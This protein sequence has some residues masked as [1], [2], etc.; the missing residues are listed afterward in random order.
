MSA[1]GEHQS[2]IYLGQGDVRGTLA[3]TSV[4]INGATPF[5]KDGFVKMNLRGIP[6]L[7]R[8]ECPNSSLREGGRHP[9]SMCGLTHAFGLVEQ[10]VGDT[11]KSGVKIVSSC[12]TAAGTLCVELCD[13]VVKDLSDNLCPQSPKA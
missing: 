10:T 8:G 13:K 11:V 6:A 3:E 2:R 4:F 7:N 5:D 1:S 12:N 9:V